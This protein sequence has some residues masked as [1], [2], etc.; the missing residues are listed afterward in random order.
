[1]GTVDVR[2]ALI[3][4]SGCSPKYTFEECKKQNK[5]KLEWGLTQYSKEE[6]L[7]RLDSMDVNDFNWGYTWTDDALSIALEEFQANGA[8]HEKWIV[9]LTAGE[10]STGHE[11]CKTS[12]DYVS[13]TVVALKTLGVEI[14][15]GAISMSQDAMDEYFGCL[16]DVTAL[17]LFDDL[18][19]SN[20]IASIISLLPINRAIFLL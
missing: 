10:P 2:V 19:V 11:A 1:M 12:A 4:Y 14:Y 18:Y 17:N 15:T 8:D 5:L 6:M 13:E 16:G 20:L 7:A 3:N 9:L